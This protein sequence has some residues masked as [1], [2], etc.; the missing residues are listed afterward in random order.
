M[1]NIKDNSTEKINIF[2]KKYSKFEN[3][4]Y[5]CKS[6]NE[7]LNLSKYFVNLENG[8][9]GIIVKLNN[10]VDLKN[11]KNYTNYGKVINYLDKLINKISLI[12]NL[13]TITGNLNENIYYRQKIIKKIIDVINE[14]F[15][16]S[17]NIDK[18]NENNI[19]EFYNTYN[20]SSTYSKYIIFKLTDNL[21]KFKSKE[22]DI[23]KYSK[24]NNLLLYIGIFLLIEMNDYNIIIIHFD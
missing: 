20:I 5:V 15:N 24:I 1:K 12:L 11:N 16:I 22:D 2:F 21:L 3:N 6:C 7:I 8:E 23:Y 18:K 4:L 10:Y 13:K 17:S 14:N 19:I 9:E